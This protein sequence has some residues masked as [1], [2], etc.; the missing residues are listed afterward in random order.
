MHLLADKVD[1]VAGGVQRC[2]AKDIGDNG[3]P[4]PRADQ[5]RCR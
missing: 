2:M 1:I 3:Y 5:G 4:I